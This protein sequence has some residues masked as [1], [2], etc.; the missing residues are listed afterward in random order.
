MLL[1]SL[2]QTQVGLGARRENPVELHGGGVPGGPR[3]G[4]ERGLLAPHRHHH[5]SLGTL[6]SSSPHTA[7]SSSF[8]FNHFFFF[9]I[10]LPNWGGWQRSRFFP[11]YIFKILH[12]SRA[13]VCVRVCAHH[14]G[15]QPSDSHLQNKLGNFFGA[16]QRQAWGKSTRVKFILSKQCLWCKRNNKKIIIISRQKQNSTARKLCK[17]VIILFNKIISDKS[18]SL[19][20]YT[21]ECSWRQTQIL[22]IHIHLLFT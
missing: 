6:T 17:T 2:V 10:I 22:E 19:C 9:F 14:D 1:L 21:G 7:P 8:F 5:R 13:C 18:S 16:L 4:G 3:P 11:A 12:L 15:P 20:W